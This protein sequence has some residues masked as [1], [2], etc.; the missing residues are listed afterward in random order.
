M[1]LKIKTFKNLNLTFRL[2]LESEASSGSCPPFEIG[3]VFYQNANNCKL[4]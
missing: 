4:I 1:V 2:S 3:V